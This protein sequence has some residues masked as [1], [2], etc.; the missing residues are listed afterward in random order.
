[1]TREACIE[2]IS[3]GYLA[4]NSCEKFSGQIKAWNILNPTEAI[5]LEEVRDYMI[6]HSV[7]NSTLIE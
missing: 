2:F 4:G 7:E 1:M 3:D 6:K 5:E